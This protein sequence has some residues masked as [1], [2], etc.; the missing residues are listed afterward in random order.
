MYSRDELTRVAV[1][2]YQMI[3][4]VK[5]KHFKPDAPRA[6]RIADQVELTDSESQ[7]TDSSNDEPRQEDVESTPCNMGHRAPWD[8]LP[9]DE[10]RRLKVHTFSGVAHIASKRDPTY[11][12][13]GGELRRTMGASQRDRTMQTCQF[14]C[15]AASESCRRCQ[16]GVYGQAEE[17]CLKWRGPKDCSAFRA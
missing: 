10:L 8:D 11:L 3:R 14:A 9:L 1:V 2:I 6:E 5:N 7:Q 17:P 12:C 15:S 13:V 16:H 4:N